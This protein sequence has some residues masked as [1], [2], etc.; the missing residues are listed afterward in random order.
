MLRSTWPL[1]FLKCG[2]IAGGGGSPP[3]SG[4]TAL[5]LR[6]LRN[7]QFWGPFGSARTSL[8]EINFKFGGSEIGKTGTTAFEGGSGSVNSAASAA[9]DDSSATNWSR[10]GTDGSCYAGLRGY[11]SPVT[12][13]SV[14]LVGNATPEEMPT[15]FVAEGSVDTTNGS[16]GTWYGFY[17]S[18][19][20]TWSTNETKSFSIV[21]SAP[22]ICWGQYPAISG[23]DHSAGQTVTCSSG[24]W[25]YAPTS[26]AY[27]WKKNGVVVVGATSP[28]LLI[29]AGDVGAVLTCEVTA[30]NATG[31]TVAI[32][33]P[34]IGGEV[35]HRYWAAKANAV[36]G[37]GAYVAAHEI[38][39]FET[40]N[41]GFDIC[42]GGTPIADSAFA[43]LPATNA[44]DNKPD[45]TTL[46]ACNG[47]GTNAFIGYDFGASNAK[48][49][50]QLNWTA[51]NDASYT[52][53][54]TSLGLIWS[55]TSATGPWTQK[56]AK[57]GI[58]FTQ[59]QRRLF[60]A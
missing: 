1:S 27:Q 60:T 20:L 44:F 34:I 45:T 11:S 32:G 8:V 3:P 12:P 24:T 15:R 54:P 53:Y 37:G 48:N 36:N 31:S 23:N 51:R 33:G 42:N 10:T 4:Y 50:N 25:C 7:G 30:T 52:Q 2:A 13:D 56:F 38:E 6:S 22:V 29:Q 41:V 9:F 57:T 5:R 14:E 17:A 18:G 47:T 43:G 19:D 40:P 28:S 26:I 21:A 39:M 46:W 58:T 16:D 55:D 59:G 35:A 49:I